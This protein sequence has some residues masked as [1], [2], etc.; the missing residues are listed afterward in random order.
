MFKNAP[1]NYRPPLPF[2]VLLLAFL[3]CITGNAAHGQQRVANYA[4]GK[5]GTKNYE[6]LSFWTENNERQEITYSYGEEDK[7]IKLSYQ[8][9]DTFKG[10]PCFKVEFSN[11]KLLYVIPKRMSLRVVDSDGQ[12]NKLFRW[13]YEGPRNGIGTFC[14]VCAEDEREAMRLI[15]RFFL[16]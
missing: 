10:E 4:F 12:Y 8:G 6:H 5:I 13:E 1:L 14:S 15:R 16:K 3:V 2:C 11:G 9:V 7:E